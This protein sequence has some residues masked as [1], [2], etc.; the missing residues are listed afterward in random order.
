MGPVQSG[1]L[2]R[3]HP[4]L[5]KRWV[6]PG[7]GSQNFRPSPQSDSEESQAPKVSRLPRKSGTG[8]DFGVLRPSD[9]GRHPYSSPTKE[10]D[11]MQEDPVERVPGS[12]PG[13][14]PLKG[15]N[16]L[17]ALAERDSKLATRKRV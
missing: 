1:W 7:R 6:E 12:R 11:S 15:E 9:G 2:R 13:K 5:A 14:M 17:D 16:V 8:R 10:S 3:N 4:E